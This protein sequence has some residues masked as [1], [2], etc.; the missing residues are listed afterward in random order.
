M[1]EIEHLSATVD[2]ELA[3][4]RLDK[5]LAQVFSDYSRARLQQWVC[6]GVVLVDGKQLRSKD[7]LRGGEQIEITV[8][9]EEEVDSKP[10][11][12]PLDII[13]EDA[14]ILVINKP[15]GLVVHPAAGNREGTMLNALLHR[16]PELA[17]VPRAGIVHRLDKDTSGLLVV[18]RTLKSQKV[19]TEQIQRREFEREYQAVVNG[20]MTAGGT[21]DA[22][23][24]R[25][26]TARTRMA[27]VGRGKEA[28]THYRVIKRFR[29]HTH[30]LVKLETGR[31]HQIRVH[32]AHIRYPIVGDPVYGG[33]LRIPKGCGE[34]L[35]GMLRTFKRQA[36]HAAKLG[37][38]HPDS[39]EMMS[40]EAPL[41]TDM[42]R[43]LQV[44]D[45]DL[46]LAE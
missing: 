45:E 6:D 7:K 26:P 28:R 12:I 34:V 13:Y 43:L 30:A 11:A 39:G 36:L 2:D 23:I 16:A 1:S 25:H 22:A 3:G 33:R 29:S 20:V 21:V 14:S 24:G 42:S 18:A 46:K 9:L 41:P 37:L 32:M 4:Q 10:E 17:N 27:V 8:E 19:L 44:L 15:V 31:T 35:N 38:V 5:I 40:W